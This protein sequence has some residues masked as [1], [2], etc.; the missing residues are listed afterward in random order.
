M[1][2]LTD[3][4]GTMGVKALGGPLKRMLGRVVPKALALR[5]TKNLAL[6]FH[7]G[8]ANVD[9]SKLSISN[10]FRCHCRTKGITL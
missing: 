7:N 3:R 1:L 6:A 10:C 9:V 5:P 4:L 8:I 2:E